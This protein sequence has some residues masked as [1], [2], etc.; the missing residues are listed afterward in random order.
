MVRVGVGV[1]RAEARTPNGCVDKI[2]VFIEAEIDLV[3]HVPAL[4]LCKVC[5]YHADLCA[6]SVFL[7]GYHAAFGY[8]HIAQV[9]CGNAGK[10]VCGHNAEGAGIYVIRPRYLLILL[11]HFRFAFQFVVF[12]Y[13]EWIFVRIVTRYVFTTAD[14]LTIII[15]PKKFV[16][17]YSESLYFI[18]AVGRVESIAT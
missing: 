17:C 10:I 5:A 6:G 13:P 9:E 3:A 8:E 11:Q 2:V 4:Q 14:G 1:A 12:I 15:A 18:K 7:L 16:S